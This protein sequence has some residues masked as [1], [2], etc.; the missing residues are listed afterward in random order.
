M[1]VAQALVMAMQTWGMIGA[2]VAA[3]FLTIGIDRIDEDARGA[4]VFR[5]L[6]I[7][8]VLLIWPIVL[9]RW[10]Q[11]ETERAAWANRY[12]PVRASYGLAIIAMSIGILI[13]VIAGLSV[14]QTW[15]ADI[16]PVQLTE[17]ASQ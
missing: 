8:G 13:I 16:A 17:G 2:L 11:I 3:V 4:Y 10:W 15:P 1:D 7:P 6:L 14:R 5:P 9:W 12:R